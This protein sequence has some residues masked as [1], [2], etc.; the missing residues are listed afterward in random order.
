MASHV[1]VIATDLRRTTIKVTPG[2]Y[3]IDVL[4]EACKKLNLPAD[5]YLVKHKQKTV[6][7]SVPFRT[8]GLTGGAKLEL[9]QKSKTPSAVQVALQVP[10]PEGK[11]IPG[12]RLIQKFPSNLSLWKILR[13]FESGDASAGRTLNFTARGVAQLVGGASSGGGQLF[14]ETPV[15]NIMGREYAT[16][17]DFQKTLSQL[18]YNSGSV[19]IRLSYRATDQTLYDAMEHISKAF[20]EAEDGEKEPEATSGKDKAPENLP[21]PSEDTPMANT[22]PESAPEADS[23]QQ[24]SAQVSETP[25]ETDAAPG[26]PES[27]T[28][29]AS[30]SVPENSLQPVHVFLAPTGSAPAAAQ[31]PV[32]EG[33]YTPT[34]A[35]AQLHQA[36]L[37]EHSRNKRL[38]SD[39]ELEEKAAAEAAKIA[40]VKSVL[41]KIRFPDN[42]SSEWEVG[43]TAT[44]GFLYEAVRHVMADSSQPFRLSLPGSKLIIKDNT[45]PSNS[46][47]KNY[48]FTGRV[49]LNVVWDDSVKPDVRKRPFLK[50]A[51]AQQ[52][53]AVQVP[54]VPQVEEEKGQPVVQTAKKEEKEPGSLE[55]KLPKW[56]KMGKK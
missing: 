28:L 38:L 39:K 1:V 48:K 35:H 37:L 17:A 11:E 43:P 36:R 18:G 25:A 30:S 7:L 34:I 32:S 12:G 10:H 4:Q 44:G 14:Y 24:Q 31:A 9:V 22:E 49:L 47:V 50:Q 45:N 51:V 41:V 40:A 2:T 13:Q 3:L 23:S 29:A 26:A 55:K 15:L 19:L 5:A 54:K 42:T 52:G 53:Q 27:D 33:D 56:F 16:F 46:L 6:D 21:E 8:S 20:K